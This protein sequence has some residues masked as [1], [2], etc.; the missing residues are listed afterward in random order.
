MQVESGQFE[1]LLDGGSDGDFLRALLENIEDGI[2]ACDAGGVLRYFNRAAWEFHGLSAE[3]L[4]PEKWAQHYDLFYADGQTPM[5]T[6]DVPLYRALRDG[7]VTG[8]EMVIAPRRG[9]RRRHL[10]A[11]GRAIF[12]RSG[13]K[14]G[15]VV[16]MHEVTDRKAADELRDLAQRL[17]EREARSKATI[18]TA[19]DCI[20]GMDH[21]GRITEWNPAAERVFGFTRDEVLGQEMCQFIIPPEFCEA[22]REGI[23]RYVST[24]TSDV[25]GQRM[26]MPALRKG[27][28]R[29]TSELAITRN[30]GE[31]PTFTGFMRDVTAERQAQKLQGLLVSLDDAVRR[32]K[33]PDEITATS[34]RILGQHLNVDRCAYAEVDAEHDAMVLTGNFTRGTKSIVG[35]LKLSDFGPEFVRLMHED[36]AYV[37]TD[38]DTHSP[39]LDVAAYHAAQ[40]RAVIS[41]PL[42]KGGRFVAGMAVHQTSPR[43]WTQHE[44][45]LVRTVAS[46]CWESIERARAVRTLEQNL[47]QIETV[48]SSVADGVVASDP[49]GNL[50]EWN[51]AA[52]AIHGYG[53]LAEARKHLSE[54]P[55]T[56]ELRTVAGE[57]IPFEQWPMPRALRGETFSTYEVRLRRIDQGWEKF[58]DYKGTPIRDHRGEIALAVLTVHDISERK[59]AENALAES[60]S[61]F[62]QLANTIPQLAWMADPSGWVFWYNDRW[63]EYTGTTPRDMEGWGWQSVHDPQELPRVLEGWKRSIETGERF[64]MTFPLKGADGTFRPFLT[65]VNPLRDAEGRVTLWFGTNTDLSDRVKLDERFRITADSAPVLIWISDT[66]KACTWFNKPWLD[67]TGRTMAQEYGNGWADGV[68]PDDFERCLKTYTSNFDARSPFRMEYRLR[69]HDREW[70]WVVDNGAPLFEGPG[71]AF[72]GFVGSCLDI[73]DMKEAEAERQQLLDSERTA[74]ENAERASRLKDDF[75]ATLS[76]EL[77]TPLNAILGWSQ[78]LRR[79]RADDAESVAEGLDII[80]RNARVQAQLIADLLDMSAITSG[81]VRLN[82]LRVTLPEVLEAAVASVKPSAD[83]K[84]IKLVKVLDSTAGPVWGDPDRLQQIFWNLLTNALK[85]TPKGGRVQVALERVNSHLEVSVSDNGKGMDVEFLPHVFDRFRQADASTTRQHGGLGLGLSIVKNLV[86]LHGGS[87]SASSPGEGKGATF[88]VS[89]PLSP[90]LDVGAPES[91]RAHPARARKADST[92]CVERLDGVTVLIVDDEADARELVRRVLRQCGAEV[93]TAGSAGEGLVI[94]REMRPDVLLTDIGMPHEDGYLLIQQVR[95][96][97]AGQGGTVPAAALTAFARSE[98]RQRA[99]RAGF[100]THIPKPVEPGEL[101]TIVASLAGR[102]LRGKS[103]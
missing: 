80:E 31:P 13:T 16:S 70:R 12:D 29:F 90:I 97:P 91:P 54:F 71:G 38:V 92:D 18:D 68:H 95:E 100:Q 46:R 26:E 20:I 15:A 64:D 82:V 60:E 33:D 103:S 35:R 56:Y 51:A 36:K 2:V 48:L 24:R 27:G 72:S 45:E 4:E 75:L 25:L 102:T 9:G 34:A 87:V 41:V 6:E 89:I 23:R 50:I 85:F 84:G 32:L 22:H 57:L 78:I 53:D 63:Y 11:S 30:P 76:H 61:K 67:F 88:V 83:A 21:E 28:E 5:R 52:L 79:G 43:A 55:K 19:L 59:R 44:V 96:L 17:A 47:A 39:P 1:Q 73:T 8:A 14:A 69:R 42:H 58:I 86:E 66:T 98:D 94:L 77:R 99:L 62:R 74:R 7:T 65:R 93:L 40:I 81:K 3:P 10:V 49:Q 37:V 101:V